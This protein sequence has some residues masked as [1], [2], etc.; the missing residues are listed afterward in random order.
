M[1][2]EEEDE[3]ESCLGNSFKAVQGQ[4]LSAA[5][6]SRESVES[7]KELVFIPGMRP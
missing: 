5:Y 1:L 3:L 7:L 2:A 4:K 6:S